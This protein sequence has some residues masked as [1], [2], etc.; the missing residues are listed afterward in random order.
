MLETGIHTT[1]IFWKIY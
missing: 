1:D